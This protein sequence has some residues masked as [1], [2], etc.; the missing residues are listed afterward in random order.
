MAMSEIE[1]KWVRENAPFYTIKEMAES[2]NRHPRTLQNLCRAE[3]IKWKGWRPARVQSEEER[4]ARRQAA[5]DRRAEREG[6][7]ERG[8][9]RSSLVFSA[10]EDVK[11]II[12]GPWGLKK[13]S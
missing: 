3:D 12:R 6:K 10:S 9:H 1:K 4:E 5:L 8:P 13:C 7:K 11:N 2:L